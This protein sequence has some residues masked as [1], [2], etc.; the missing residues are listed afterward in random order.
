MMRGNSIIT[1]H[2]VFIITFYAATLLKFFFADKD[3]DFF[4]ATLSTLNNY[5]KKI[6]REVY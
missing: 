5:S 1:F 4:K 6:F 3:F 2:H